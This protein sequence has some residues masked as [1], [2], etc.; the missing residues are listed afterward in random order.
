VEEVVYML[1]SL[2]EKLISVFAFGG[3]IEFSNS[4]EETVK[5]TAIA[6]QR[7]L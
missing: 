2:I 4:T 3:I 5:A 6:S 1:H 7:F